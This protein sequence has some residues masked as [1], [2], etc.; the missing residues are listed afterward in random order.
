[1][2]TLQGRE[3]ERGKNKGQTF[4]RHTLENTLI[5]TQSS[6]EAMHDP[7]SILIH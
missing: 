4:Q 6:Q 3:R 7:I 5:P 2:L 1:M